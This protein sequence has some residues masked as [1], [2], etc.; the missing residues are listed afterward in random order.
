MFDKPIKGFVMSK[1]HWESL[2]ARIIPTTQ[3]LGIPVYVTQYLPDSDENIY[4][5]YEESDDPISLY[6]NPTRI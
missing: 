5:M 6:L 2:E 4:I 3:F 1:K